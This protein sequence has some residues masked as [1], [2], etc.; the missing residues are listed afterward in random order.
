MARDVGDFGFRGIRFNGFR[1]SHC[2]SGDLLKPDNPAK[3]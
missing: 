3:E 2:A 1:G